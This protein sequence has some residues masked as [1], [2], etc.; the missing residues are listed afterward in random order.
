MVSW[1]LPQLQTGDHCLNKN[2]E[3]GRAMPPTSVLFHQL[4]SVTQSCLTLCDPLD[5]STPGLPV[6]HQLPEFTQT[7]VHWV[8]DA[9]QPSHP[10]LSP[11]H[12]ENKNLTGNI[13]PPTPRPSRLHLCFNN[14]NGVTWPWS[15]LQ[16]SLGKRSLVFP[17]DRGWWWLRGQLTQESTTS[18]K[19]R[20]VPN[21]KTS[22]FLFI[23]AFLL[24]T[25]IN[26]VKV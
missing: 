26:S 4:S 23:N 10:L 8:S 22:V 14:Q 25:Q 24:D 11:S 5:C 1:Q 13:P 20:E 21:S 7:H 15:F 16:R 9:I 18:L 6:H 3:R 17:R 12:Q 19:W 2:K